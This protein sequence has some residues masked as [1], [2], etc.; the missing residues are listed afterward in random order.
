MGILMHIST[1]HF[2]QVI[3]PKSSLFHTIFIFD[4][5]HQFLCSQTAT[6]LFIILYLIE[7]VL[8]QKNRIIALFKILALQHLKPIFTELSVDRYSSTLLL[9]GSQ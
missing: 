6:L 9:N 8:K 3:Q 1:K 4:I 2:Y 5:V 7:N